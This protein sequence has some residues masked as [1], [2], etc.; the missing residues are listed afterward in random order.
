MTDPQQSSFE[1]ALGEC[2]QAL[3]RDRLRAV[4]DAF[5]FVQ[6]GANDGVNFDW[7][8]QFV[9]THRLRG[10]VVEPLPDL[11][12]ELCANY[13]AHPQVVPVNVAIHRT[14]REI[15]LYRVDMAKAAGLPEWVKAIAS[16]D[17]DHHRKSGTPSEVI[18]AERVRCVTFAELLDQQRIDRIDF[19]QIDIEGYDHEIIRMIDFTRLRPAIIRFEHNL[20]KRVMRRE[21]FLDCMRLL[22]D[23]GYYILMDP[24][25][26]VAYTR[27]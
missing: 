15:D 8:Y 10:V 18:R 12:R 9:T 3:L 14:A 13:R 7:V 11:F 22:V 20:S 6:I 21:D 5:F 17:P 1:A 2:V 26:A 16:V 4:G 19:L 23:A 27:E 24:M 25:D